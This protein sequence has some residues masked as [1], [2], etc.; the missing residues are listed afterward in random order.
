MGCQAVERG[1]GP[2]RTQDIGSVEEPGR[3][4]AA[5]DDRPQ[6]AVGLEAQ[7]LATGQ[8]VGHWLAGQGGNHGSGP[9]H[10]L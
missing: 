10:G 2:A 9:V 1:L 4:S 7:P 5:G 6:L 8:V 3:V